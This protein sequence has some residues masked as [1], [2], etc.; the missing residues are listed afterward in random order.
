MGHVP[1][2]NNVKYKEM[3]F[4]EITNKVDATYYY[5]NTNNTRTDSDQNKK[6]PVVGGGKRKSKK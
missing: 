1:A 6:I 4:P 5:S 2:A 3:A